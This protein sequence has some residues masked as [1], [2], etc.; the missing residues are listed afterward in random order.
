MQKKLIELCI[1]HQILRSQGNC[2]FV[3]RNAGPDPSLAPEGWYLELIDDVARDL[4]D[5]KV[6]QSTLINTLQEKGFPFQR[7]DKRP[8]DMAEQMFTNIL[9][10]EESQ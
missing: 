4:M 7:I 5:D 6:G 10:T 1:Q 8:F 2:V 3:Y 9:K